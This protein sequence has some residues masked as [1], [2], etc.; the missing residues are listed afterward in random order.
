[1][2]SLIPR[3]LGT[4]PAGFTLVELSFGKFKT[5]SRRKRNAF[6][7][8]ELL[9]V[10]AIIGILVALLLPAIQAAREAARR[11]QCMNHMKQLA[12][13]CMNHESTH[14]HLPSGGWGWD[15]VGDADK[16]SGEDQPGSWLYNILPY[17][18][19]EARHNMPK[20][21]SP[22]SLTAPQ[23][24]G[25]RAMVYMAAPPAFHCPSRRAPLPYKVEAHHAQFAVNAQRNEVGAD[26]FVGISDYAANGGD[27][28]DCESR[29]PQTFLLGERKDRA[30]RQTWSLVQNTVGLKW[31]NTTYLTGVMF[32]LSEIKLRHITDGASKTYMCGERNVRSSNY[33]RE[34]LRPDGSALIDGGDSWGWAWGFC[35]DN[36]RSGQQPPLADNPLVVA[37]VFGAAH[38]GTFHMAFCDGHVEALSY[39]IDLLVHQNN[40]NRRDDG[41]TT[42]R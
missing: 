35:R 37:D 3:R 10:I 26:F 30:A 5:V 11:S 29:G 15:W 14:K 25:A 31:D 32:Q 19:E 24:D 2:R 22:G 41:A 17:M 42:T 20:D 39:D 4:A 8:V 36:T 27:G 1:M 34:A 38:P 9:V 18:E 40:A 13:A 7:L 21:G 16:G 23:L 28:P 33:D 6:T 12:L